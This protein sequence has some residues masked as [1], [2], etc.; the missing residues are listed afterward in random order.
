MLCGFLI[1]AHVTKL[2]CTGHNY[3]TSAKK[4]IL[5]NIT[6]IESED[7]SH[8]KTNWTK[9]VSLNYSIG[10]GKSAIL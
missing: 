5:Q 9:M 8:E 4:N 7:Y 6:L 2:Q 3:L 10:S 1:F